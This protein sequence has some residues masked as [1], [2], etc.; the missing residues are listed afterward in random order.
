L[1]GYIAP[2][3]HIVHTP[4]DTE[5]EAWVTRVVQHD[6]PALEEGD[7]FDVEILEEEAS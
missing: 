6:V 1:F 7:I 3:E 4:A 2:Q 5:L